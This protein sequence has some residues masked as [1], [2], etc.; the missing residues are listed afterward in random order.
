MSAPPRLVALYTAP[1]AGAP[2]V[3]VPEAR[4]LAGR[5]LE[6]DRYAAGEGSF[7]RWPGRGR[8]V[9]LISAEA[10]REAEAAFSVSLSAGEHR[11]NLVVEGLDP[12]LL[13]GV[14]FQ[15][16]EARFEGVRLCAP[17]KYLVRVTGQA[18]AFDALVGRGGLRAEVAAGGTIREGD[19][20]LWDPADRARAPRLPG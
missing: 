1:A 8:A 19:A 10:L 4:A 16:G 14:P 13:R 11:R 3:R 6:G 18:E 15:I 5:G 20:V 2:V 17:C 9:T 7:S 12:A